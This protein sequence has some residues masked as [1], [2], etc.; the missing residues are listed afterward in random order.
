MSSSLPSARVTPSPTQAPVPDDESSY[1]KGHCRYILLNSSIKGQRCGCT[2]FI[3]NKSLPG[4]TCD[5]GHLAVYHIPDR[6]PTNPSERGLGLAEIDQL[7]KR[8]ETLEKERQQRLERERN[9]DHSFLTMS[10][11]HNKLDELSQQFDTVTQDQNLETT[12]AFAQI[13]SLWTNLDKWKARMDEM[14]LRFESRCSQTEAFMA[15]INNRQKELDD[16]QLEIIERLDTLEALDK[17]ESIEDDSLVTP[18]EWTRSS[19]RSRRRRL[20]ASDSIASYP[21][22]CLG[23]GLDFCRSQNPS[24]TEQNILDVPPRSLPLRHH[25]WTVHISLLPHANLGMPF[26]KDTKAYH[27]CLSRGLHQMVAVQ[28]TDNDSFVKAVEHSFGKLLQGRAWMPLQAMLCNANKL[29]GLPMV[30]KLDEQLI[31]HPYTLDFLKNFCAVCDPSGKMD[32]LYI[33]M[34]SETFSWQFLKKSPIFL[35]GLENCWEYDEQLDKNG[36]NEESAGTIVTPALGRSP[37]AGSSSNSASTQSFTKSTSTPISSHSS[38][39]SSSSTGG[40]YQKKRSVSQISRTSSFG[41][42]TIS[43]SDS[44]RQKM[45]RT[46]LP[47]TKIGAQ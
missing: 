34:R 18:N 44:S 38:M 27:R 12:K 21:V 15:R 32:S 31:E 42:G 3:R 13:Y 33:V 6:E 1:P 25:T 29:Q 47:T 9:D 2:G 43:E 39:V 26:E 24:M 40:P 46:C 36:L 22:S 37:G 28:G 4:L 35:E 41:S 10:A 8:I 19:S 7:R 17:E 30:R 14:F 20:S 23:M 45:A 11:L 16:E 5:C